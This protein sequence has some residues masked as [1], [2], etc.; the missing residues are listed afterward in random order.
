MGSDVKR[1]RPAR[2]AEPDG[3]T[4]LLAA[5]RREFGMRGFAATT[6][7]HLLDGAGVNPPTLY[8]HFGGKF[9]LFVEAA[10][11]A[12]SEVLAA[13]RSATSDPAPTSFAE[14]VDAIL[15]VSVAL[16]GRDDELAKL[17]QVIEFELPR[18]EGLDEAL[19]P[20]LREFRGLFDDVAAVAP[21]SLARDP[22]ERRDLARALIAMINGLNGEALLLPRRTEFAGLVGRMRCLLDTRT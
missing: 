11:L 6:L 10:K 3:R 9:G 21:R 17:F 5:A 14:C 16:V 22:G 4:R 7:D 19:R 18:L 20:T 12:Y 1:G 2:R 13:F 8:H 15:D